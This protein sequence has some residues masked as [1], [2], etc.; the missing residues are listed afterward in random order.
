MQTQNGTENFNDEP[1]E[2]VGSIR[3]LSPLF[4]YAKLNFIKLFKDVL[5]RSGAFTT[6]SVAYH[7]IT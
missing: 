5:E 2:T 3:K 1:T 4:Y 6:T 7:S